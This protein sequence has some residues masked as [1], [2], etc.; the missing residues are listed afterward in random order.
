M[1]FLDGRIAT[2]KTSS[3]FRAVLRK[4]FASDV[5]EGRISRTGNRFVTF[6]S[7][8]ESHRMKILTSLVNE[9]YHVCAGISGLATY[10][11]LCKVLPASSSHT[12]PVYESQKPR[13]KGLPATADQPLPKPEGLTDSTTV[14]ENSIGLGPS[15]V[16]YI[17]NRLS[18]LFKAQDYVNQNYTFKS[19]R[20]HTLSVTSAGDRGPS[21]EFTISYSR[22]SPTVSTEDGRGRR[23]Q[24]S[25]GDK[26]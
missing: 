13:K 23:D 10:L 25:E 14:V 19:A 2:G 15:I 7:T 26:G 12:I 6:K 22:E 20:G 16:K 9:D 18:E 21:K 11:Q 4:M 24:V 3:Q 8:A 5:L 1:G 17:G